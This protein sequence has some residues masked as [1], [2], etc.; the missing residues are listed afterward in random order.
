M[1]A[2]V[3]DVRQML[4][5]KLRAEEIEGS[6]HQK[7]RI[8]ENEMLVARTVLSRS[9]GEVSNTILGQIGVQLGVNRHQMRGLLDCSWSR[10][11]YIAH[12][13]KTD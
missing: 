9:Y 11:D 2:K 6:K 1:P 4:V 10:D 12:V 5:G 13:L 8:I 3:R 7:Y